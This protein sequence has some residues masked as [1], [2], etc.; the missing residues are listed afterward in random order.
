MRLAHRLAGAVLAPGLA[1][2]VTASL[3]ATTTETSYA[4]PAPG[5]AT[6]GVATTGVATTGLAPAGLARAGHRWPGHPGRRIVVHRVRRGETAIGLAVRYHAWTRELLALNHLTMRS[7]LRVGQ[8]VRIPVVLAALRHHRRHHHAGRH[9]HR[10]H[11]HAA[12]HHRRHHHA[13]HPKRHLSLQARG[14]RHYR[15][16]R[17]QVAHRIAAEARRRGVSPT[18]AQAIG[19]QESGWFQP[20]VSGAGAIG[21]MQLLPSTGRWMEGYVGRRLNLR[22]TWDN[23]EAGVV[24]IHVLQRN[25]RDT[26]HAIGAYYEGLGGVRNG[27]GKDTRRYVRSVVAIQRRLAA[28]RTP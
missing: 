17:A 12:R 4:A 2:A 9:H 11:H 19:W 16:T 28:G 26:R 20:V 3:L 7:R 27:M 14:W 5:L 22:D 15:M 23:V 13:R 1:V 21:V 10:R 6:T 18:L 8:R 25:T 24:L